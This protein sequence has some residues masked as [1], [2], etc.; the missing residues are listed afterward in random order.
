MSSVFLCSA[1]VCC[2]L[3]VW[4]MY[5]LTYYDKPELPGT[6]KI[7]NISDLGFGPK[8]QLLVFDFDVSTIDMTDKKF[9]KVT[10]SSTDGGA[11]HTAGIEIK[12]AGLN[13][14]DKL[15]Y[16]FEIWAPDEDDIPCTSIETCD[17]DK[18]E[19]FDFGEDYED[20]VLRG[21]YFEP[22]FFRDTVASQMQGGILQHTLV[23][24]VFRHNDE[25]FYE[26]VY[27]LYPAIQRRVLEKRLDWDSKG[28]KEDCEDNPS[29]SDIEETALIGEYTNPTD[30][31]KGCDWIDHIKMRYPKCDIG[32]CYHEHIK[33]YFS[34]IT[35]ENSSAVD[36][37]MISF[38]HT[39]YVEQML[40]GADF[41]LSSQYFY[42]DPT[43]VLHSGPRWDY[44]L[45]IW[46]VHSLTSW[47]VDTL[48]S[49]VTPAKI[50]VNL[51]KNSD[52]IKLLELHR[53]NVT[54]ANLDVS[55]QVLAQRRNQ[56]ELG[57]FDRNIERWGGFGTQ[58]VPYMQH[59][60]QK[61]TDGRVKDT[62]QEELDF[63]SAKIKQR[64]S[65]MKNHKIQNFKFVT[66]PWVT[67]G[68]LFA[69]TPLLLVFLSIPVIL[70]L[71]CCF[72]P[73][74]NDKYVSL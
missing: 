70:V 12:G 34:V 73:N 62:W 40:L 25:Y 24:V 9:T 8:K 51:G 48:M 36:M 16:A 55:L 39:F 14:R 47:D 54:Q 71:F 52:F 74:R 19:L 15:N 45:G 13:E 41:P 68:L 57:Y 30:R 3:F 10:W 38:M 2:C 17:D 58:L 72:A 23:E 29:Q 27:I 6:V 46:R 44:D 33:K 31:K 4:I 69:Y 32:S 43:G 49:G 22:T 7:S 26:G 11:T 5:D 60:Y 64:A 42:K 63:I 21:G 59:M 20:Y 65:W 66:G 37:D 50:W 35:G 61:H 67:I 18:A 1:I 56:F 28:K 53:K